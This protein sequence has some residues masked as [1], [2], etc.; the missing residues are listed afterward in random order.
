MSLH[1]L[2]PAD[3]QRREYPHLATA[4]DSWVCWKYIDGT[5][6][7]HSPFSDLPKHSDDGP[8]RWSWSHPENLTDYETAY[9]WAKKVPGYEGVG[10]ILQDGNDPYKDPAD[11]LVFIDLDDV[12]DKET[13]TV[14]P[15]AWELVDRMDTY[16]DLSASWFND[17]KDTAGIHLIGV[18]ELPE[19]TRTVQD[20]LPDHPDF[21]AAEIEVYDGKRFCAMSGV[22]LTPSNRDVTDVQYWVNRLTRRFETTDPT[23]GNESPGAV[24]IDNS[25]FEDVE[26]V[27]DFDRIKDAIDSV[28]RRDIRL[29]SQET[30]ERASGVIDYDPAYRQSDSGKGM[31]WFPD[32]EVWVDRDGQHYMDALQ[33]VALEENV[34][35]VNTPRDYP[36]GEAFW[37]ALERL[38]E[39]GANIPRYTGNE[40]DRLGLHKNADS[41]EEQIEQ[42]VA[43]LEVL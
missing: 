25:T 15:Y 31:A 28:G 10:F 29:T 19:H 32:N 9:D 5:K 26:Y 38:R 22:W 42:A 16:A 35:G 36:S 23:G 33:V 7:A 34:D 2:T 20:S 41:Q 3:W 24:D 14:H 8:D 27:D 43:G 21:P 4:Y 1:E 17:D 39:R 6:Q 18:G 12:V 37:V 13:G 40:K 11:P 30:N